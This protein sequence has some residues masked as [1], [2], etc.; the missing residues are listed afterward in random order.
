MNINDG[1]KRQKIANMTGDFFAE[2][3]ARILIEQVQKDCKSI[4]HKEAIVF[5]VKRRLI[6]PRCQ[7]LYTT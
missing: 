4:R 7:W 2:Q 3:L 1:C 5:Y 6:F